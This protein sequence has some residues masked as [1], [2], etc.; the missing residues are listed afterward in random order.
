[1]TDMSSLAVQPLDDGGVVGGFDDGSF[2]LLPAQAHYMMVEQAL[3]ATGQSSILNISVA[4]RIHEPLDAD[5]LQACINA[6]VN[7]NDALRLV[8]VNDGG[9]LRQRVLDDVHLACPVVE[10]E[11]SSIE[12]RL[13][14]GLEHASQMHQR[15]FRFTQEPSVRFAVVPLGSHEFLLAAVCHHWVADAYTGQLLVD[16]VL[17]VYRGGEPDAARPS[18]R[19]FVEHEFALRSSEEGA[20]QIRYWEE[21]IA[22][23][24]PVD[25]S[26][27]A[28][29]RAQ[30]LEDCAWV[31]D[32]EL[33][34]R[35]A[36]RYTTSAFVIALVA[37]HVGIA[38][39]LGD[40]DICVFFAYVGRNRHFSKT[41]GLLSRSLPH[42]L[43]MHSQDTAAD[44]VRQARV[45]VSRAILN[46]A[47]GR[48]SKAPVQFLL[49]FIDDSAAESIRQGGVEILAV[50]AGDDQT[51]VLVFGPRDDGTRISVGLSGH[52]DMFSGEFIH[53]VRS[54]M[55]RFLVALADEPD[56]TI[57]QLRDDLSQDFSCQ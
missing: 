46:H 48:Y 27:T 7:A 33:L 30:T 1:M 40:D 51:P 32:R 56:T 8:L 3:A 57:G 10:P 4:W 16:D 14:W 25:V 37:F 22:G 52:P 31:W 21:H 18:F 20:R 26:R 19:E 5:R 41:Y 9:S 43:T 12:E 44:L 24:M 49:S 11:G 50:P 47:M 6:V 39:A 35:T 42:R 45:S 54:G 53:R 29:G 13:Q 23:H 28:R 36:A 17:R 55:D 38:M 2:P 34:V 15:P